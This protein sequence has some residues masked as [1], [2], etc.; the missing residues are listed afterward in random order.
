MDRSIQFLFAHDVPQSEGATIHPIVPPSPEPNDDDK[1]GFTL[2]VAA[3]LDRES[4]EG[5]ERAVVIPIGK[6]RAPTLA[7]SA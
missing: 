6:P 2:D 7:D 5:D 1:I 3:R 4:E